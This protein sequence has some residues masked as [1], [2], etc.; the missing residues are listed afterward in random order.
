MIGF[1][2]LLKHVESTL[3]A[4]SSYGEA[5]FH[6]TRGLTFLFLNGSLIGAST[7]DVTGVAFR[8]VYSGGLGFA[9]TSD[10]SSESLREAAFRA[11]A[12]AKASSLVLKRGVAMS[13]SPLGSARYSVVEAKPLEDV[14][15]EDK[16]RIVGEMI[17][18][19]DLKKDPMRVTN[20]M[21]VYSETIEYKV[22]VNSEG[23]RVESRIPRVSIF[24][25]ISASSGERRANRWNSLAASGGLEV[26][27]KVK[28]TEE[29]QDDVN[30]LYINLV[31]AADPPKGRM[32][33]VL[34]PEIVGLA[35]HESVG[36]PSEADRVLGREAAQAGLSYRSEYR[37]EYIGSPKV[38]VYD[39]PTIPGSYGFYLYDDEGVP[40]KRRTLIDKGRLAE[41]L[42]NRETA[43]VYGVES[44]ASARSTN[45]RS[46]PIVRMA[47][48][49]MAP[50]DYSFEELVEDVKEGVYLRKYMEWNID[51]YRWVAR[52]VG[53]EAYM[54]RN[55]RLEE[56]VR[57]VV[58]EANTREFLSSVDAVGRDLQF[59]A[60]TC[61]KG[62]PPQP[63]P[64]WMGGPHIRL[65]GVVVG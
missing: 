36:H 47:N 11:V 45:Y 4:G 33:V 38:T 64:V 30:S 57:N 44:N 46:E 16:M 41:L 21:V 55:G 26:L 53:L 8:A 59:T 28:F 56:P 5:R 51:D 52:Y 54:I 37:D 12:S 7:S 49:Y 15:V 3:A 32:D 48:T 29:F 62:E 61:G 9:S 1:H 18:S 63:M 13:P 23:V 20:Y 65:R 42:H 35:M 39:D 31:K 24:Y 2:E 10:L 14:S 19:V 58:L 27:D 43:A 60:G 6:S 50:G 22:V 34:A 17:K 40:A 25:N